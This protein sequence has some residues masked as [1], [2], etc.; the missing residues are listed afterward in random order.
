VRAGGGLAGSAGAGLS[1][2]VAQGLV[3]VQGQEAGQLGAYVC[4]NDGTV[5]KT[6]APADSTNPRIDTVVARL[7]DATYSG[8]NR[9]WRIEVVTGTPAGSPV[10][11][12][13]ATGGD[14][15][16]VLFDV[17]VPANALVP[18]TITDRRRWAVAV[19]GVM[20]LRTSAD[21]PTFVY[22]GL[23][24]ARQD[25]NELEVWDGAQWRVLATWQDTASP[26]WSAGGVVAGFSGT[27]ELWVVNRH[28]TLRMLAT[29]TG[30]NVAGA[31][32]T[33]L[34]A[35][36]IPASWRPPGQWPGVCSVGDTGSNRY[37][38]TS[39]GLVQ[40]GALTANVGDVL[41]DT[42][43]WPV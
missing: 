27:V 22:E 31:A 23:L 43:T 34:A 21:Y 42:L 8:A 39:T 25:A 33:N 20:P 37:F 14:S 2:N 17:P 35:S 9:R 11:P 12:D 3:V 7:Q 30:A 26:T 41:Q 28:A 24:V 36:A 18:G 1:V 10:S 4:P 40:F 15:Y 6:L 29:K 19:G 16:E 32:V 13:P 38:V 5:N